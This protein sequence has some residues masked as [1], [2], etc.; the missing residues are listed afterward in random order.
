M[1]RLFDYIYIISYF[2]KKIN[3]ISY[4]ANLFGD[5]SEARTPDPVI[6][7]LKARFELAT[8]LHKGDSSPT[9]LLEQ[10]HVL[11]QSELMDHFSFILSFILHIYYI[12]NF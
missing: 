10:S 12:I 3:K 2:F 8:S 6:M 5:P 4:G 9:E 1:H 7:V 11:F